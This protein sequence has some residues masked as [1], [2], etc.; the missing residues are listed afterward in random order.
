MWLLG[1]IVTRR[2]VVHTAPSHASIQQ[3]FAD[4]P[5]CSVVMYENLSCTGSI[6][7]GMNRLTSI[8]KTRNAICQHVPRR[9][10]RGRGIISPRVPYQL[11]VSTTFVRSHVLAH[12]FI[13]SHHKKSS[14]ICVLQFIAM[15]T[16]RMTSG[17]PDR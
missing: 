6:M 13:Q 12:K 5:P 2:C 17:I 11:R 14:M 9:H 4:L 15:K 1:I 10:V 7:S 16:N 3:P 8:P